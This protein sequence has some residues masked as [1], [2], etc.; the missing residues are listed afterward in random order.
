MNGQHSTERAA[1]DALLAQWRTAWPQALAS[2]SR[3]T[4]LHDALLCR[5]TV[6][7]AAEGLAGSFAMIRLADQ[8]VVIDM[9]AICKFG[10]QDYAVEI[11]AHEIGHHVLAPASATDQFRL[12]ARM[13][14]ALPTLEDK[15]PMVA[16]LYTDLCINDRLQ[17]Q[18]NLRMA[19]IYR[20]LARE[21]ATQR[22][23]RRLNE[24]G[25]LW[26]LYLRIYETLWQLDKGCLGG[27]AATKEID[28]DAWLGARVIRVYANDW[29]IGAGRFASLLLP[30]LV[31]DGGDDDALAPLHDTK[32][33]AAGC[34][35]GG[36]Q[37]IEA[38]EIDGAI[39][40]ARDPNITGLD[41][42]LAPEVQ[43]PAAQARGQAREPFEYGEILRAAGIKL[44]GHE[45]AM[46]YYRERALPHL[47]PFPTEF[48][49]PSGEPQLE[50]VEP[51]EIG[52]P[53]DEIDWLQSVMLCPR[54][55]PGLTTVRRVYSRDAA[56]A[57]ELA[58]IDLDMYVDSSGS[59]PNPQVATSY[60]AL[61]GAIIALSALRAGSSVQ[62]TLWSG[63]SQ[64]LGTAGFVR[65]SDEV[66]RVLTGFFGGATAFPIHR[67][68]ETYAGRDKQARPAHILM[69]SDDGIT[70]MFD[71]D[72]KGASGWEISAAALAAGRAGGTMALNL[73]A[74]WE[75]S[76]YSYLGLA[77]RA[78]KRARREQGWDIHA[79]A[80]MAQL[81]AFARAFSQRH[82]GGARTGPP[83]GLQNF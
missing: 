6:A 18:C 31:Q 75:N 53:L 33:A 20:L 72:E 69:I 60:L 49:G 5:T 4:R 8:S 12:L 23:A 27:T 70:T 11:L 78:L 74:D 82:Y 2:W 64:V 3:Y 14:R 25:M 57:R 46:R 17:R 48:G 67:L 65:D 44:S 79:V 39:H 56:A 54:P 26:T 16:N 21:A 51:W 28:A 10:L 29:M 22:A 45:I 41:D 15:A 66:L 13:R 43:Q 47:I 76:P 73:P 55:V 81:V 24:P 77:I 80:D 58:P 63:K 32:E 37:A 40:P 61:A 83:T 71:K 7:A 59:M 30:Y 38:D 52:D 68:R 19:D 42:D 50:A 1:L 35:P 9:E 34:V 36:L 62:V